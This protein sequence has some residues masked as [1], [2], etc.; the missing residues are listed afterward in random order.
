L[1]HEYF[2]FARDFSFSGIGE[3]EASHLTP[4]GFYPSIP[5]LPPNLRSR[6]PIC[7]TPL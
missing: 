5:T 1:N 4:N 7:S 6:C 3:G 2:Q